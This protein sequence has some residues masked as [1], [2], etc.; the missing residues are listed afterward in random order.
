MGQRN[1]AR[2][3]LPRAR[4][5]GVGGPWFA[6]KPRQHGEWV[7]STSTA[8]SNRTHLVAH[9]RVGAQRR[10]RVSRPAGVV[11][12]ETRPPHDSAHTSFFSRGAPSLFFPGS[13]TPWQVA[14]VARPH[15]H[16]LL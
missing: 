9:G 16:T 5:G 7:A 15:P 8:W 2:R 12:V 6:T 3:C 4:P 13:P 14:S 1:A 10:E 11:G